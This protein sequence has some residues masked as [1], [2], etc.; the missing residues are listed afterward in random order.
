MQI[1]M[2]R[3][4]LFILF[5]YY[6]EAKNQAHPDG[7]VSEY[8]KRADPFLFTDLGSA[9]KRIYVEFDLM[10]GDS[11]VI[12]ADYGYYLII[13]YLR[14]K[15]MPELTQLFSEITMN[16]WKEVAKIYLAQPHTGMDG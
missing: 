7:A 12:E 1:V 2:S 10:I 14:K 11:P 16:E 9:D 5:Y 6:I 15:Q 3:I 13:K 4:E 8:L